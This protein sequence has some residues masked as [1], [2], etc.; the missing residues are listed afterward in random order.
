[1]IRLRRITTSLAY[2][3][4]IDGIRFVAILSV[5]IYHLAGDVL[6]HSPAG[7]DASPR[8][9]FWFTQN[10]NFGVQLF[11]VLSGYVLALPFAEHFLGGQPPLS[12]KRYFVRRLTRLEPPYVLALIFLFVLKVIAGRGTF[13]GL[14]PHL[15]ASVFYLHNQIYSVPSSIDF[16]AWSLEIEVQF[17]ILAPFLAAVFFFSGDK[18]YRRCTLVLAIFFAALVAYHWASKP[19]IS[20][21]LIGQ[22]SYFLAGFLL[23]EFSVLEEKHR[24]FAASLGWDAVCLLAIALIVASIFAGGLIT[25]LVCPLA[26]FAAYYAAFH[27]IFIKRFLSLVF[28]SSVGGMCY[29]IYLLHNYVIAMCGGYSERFGASLSFASRLGVQLLIMTPVLLLVCGT[30]FVL[31]ERPCMQPDWPARLKCW[32]VRLLQKRGVTIAAQS[33]DFA[34]SAPSSP[35]PQ[36]EQK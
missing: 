19:R 21:S 34:V 3:P 32:V 20:L 27:S 1:M 28:I 26:V 2:R 25:W 8:W 30:F 14:I 4:E 36:R 24:A 13:T 17:Y 22:L 6:R 5:I 23:A 7:Y 10:L 12:L 11:F 9:L 15:F 33:T 31:V 18:L 16:V 35:H 29:T